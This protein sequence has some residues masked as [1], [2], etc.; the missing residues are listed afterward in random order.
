[1]K[2]KMSK[3]INDDTSN[4]GLLIVISGPSGVGKGTLCKILL[5]RVENLFLSISATT[6]PPRV[7]EVDGRNY[8]FM[9][10]EVFE[11][12]IQKG[13]FL[14][15]A[16]VYNNYY[17]TP[18]D[19]VFQMLREG[20]DVVLEIDIQGAAQVKK[21]YPEGIFIFIS[22]PNF[23]E[24]KKRIIKRGKDSKDS[25]E[26]RMKCAADEMKAALD[27]DYIVLNDDLNQAALCL[28]SIILAERCRI[29]RNMELLKKLREEWANDESVHRLTY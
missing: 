4:Q 7:G 18:K 27:Y 13:E 3:R 26:L 16:R 15:W 29:S 8:I 14:E 12:K 25:I 22:P 17:G 6:R 11:E 23:D 1:M 28:Q 19:K 5:N 21:N 2:L 10:P 24:L 20:K 9:S